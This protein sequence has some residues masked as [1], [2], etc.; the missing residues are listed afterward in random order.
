LAAAIAAAPT[1]GYLIVDSTQMNRILVNTT[2]VKYDALTDRGVNDHS[3]KNYLGQA[4]E[5]FPI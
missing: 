2:V 4:S 3:A 5:T 1:G